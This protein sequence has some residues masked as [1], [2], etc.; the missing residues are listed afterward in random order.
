MDIAIMNIVVDALV[1]S[2]KTSFSSD[3]FE[4]TFCYVAFDT[5]TKDF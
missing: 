1:K 3:W 5:Y 4:S 2:T